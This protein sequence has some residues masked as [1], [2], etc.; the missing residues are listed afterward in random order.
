MNWLDAETACAQLGIKPAS[1]YA[2][3]SRGLVRARTG[4]HDPRSS[5]YASGDIDRLLARKRAGRK[6]DSI[7]RGAIGWGDPIL[8]S[9]I[10]TVQDGRLIFRGYDAV[11]L[12]SNH[13]LEQVASILWGD[14]GLPT[15][16][17]Q[18]TVEIAQSDSKHAGLRYLAD[19]AAIAPPCSGRA[20][21]DLAH[22]AAGLLEGLSHAM[23]LGM[24]GDGAHNKLA[25]LWKLNPQQGD[26]VRQALVLLA[27][28]EL[29]PSTF[30]A[31]VAASTGASL[32]A[33]A[34]AGYAT[35][36]GPL[37]GE[38][39]AGALAY[40]YSAHRIGPE[41]AIEAIK[42]KSDQLQANQVLPGLG[43]KLYPDGDPRARAV[44]STLKPYPL[45]S[46]AIE[47]AQIAWGA[48]ANIDMALAALTV[49]LDL[50]PTA[51][52]TLFAV[53]RMAGWLAHGVEQGLA[54]FAIRPRARY[55]G[56]IGR[57]KR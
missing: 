18:S 10:A 20:R 22:E 12:S 34:L 7:A 2:Y 38:A 9:A 31:R 16:P 30:S 45:L 53:A 13:T 49:Q 3:V 52:F 56:K 23:A 4:D 32:A 51:P 54:G 6:R 43:H 19:M 8:E 41:R 11:D 35:L 28:H 46:E 57:A 29:N 17:P 42:R 27:D 21:S 50:P 36:T 15:A 48:R 40:L 1:L 25:A 37:H 26:I 5:V 55:V 39:A 47:S 24:A 33:C 44:L 14:D